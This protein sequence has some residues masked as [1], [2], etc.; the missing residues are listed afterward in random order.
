MVTIPLNCSFCGRHRGDVRKLIA[1]TEGNVAICERCIL[2]CLEVLGVD[3]TLGDIQKRRAA[4]RARE[5]AKQLGLPL[6]LLDP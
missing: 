4:Q 1:S 3:S 2:D 5:L 6:K